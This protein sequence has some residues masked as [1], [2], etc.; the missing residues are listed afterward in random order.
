LSHSTSP[1]C[2][3]FFSRSGLRNYLPG[4]ALNCDPLDRASWVARITGV[5]HCTQLPFPV[6]VFWKQITNLAQPQS[7]GKEVR[8]TLHQVEREYIWNSFV[9]KKNLVSCPY[10]LF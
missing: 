4:L 8:I 5:S 3:D 9:K 1:F 2:D 7:K 6:S 10:L